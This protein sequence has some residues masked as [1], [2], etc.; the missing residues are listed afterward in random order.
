MWT[1]KNDL[2]STLLSKI[3]VSIVEDG[4]QLHGEFDDMAFSGVGYFFGGDRIFLGY[5]VKG[6][7]INWIEM[8]T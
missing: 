3:L 8:K 4:W 1:W 5:W 6:Q 7:Q 2:R